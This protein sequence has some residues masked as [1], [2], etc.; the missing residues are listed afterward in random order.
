ME[1]ITSAWIFQVI[2]LRYCIQ[3]NMDM[4]KKGNLK[5]KK[6]GIFNNCSRKQRYKDELC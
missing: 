5:K 1:R 4:G 6:N 2:N 3:E